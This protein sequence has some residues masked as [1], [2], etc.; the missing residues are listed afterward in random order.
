MGRLGSCSPARARRT[1]LATAPTAV[2]WPITRWLKISSN[3]TN[4]SRSPAIIFSTGM[5]VQR[6]TTLAILFSLTS[7]CTVRASP[8][9][10]SSASLASSP[11]M[12]P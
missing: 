6:A 5:P 1:V 3:C 7:S 11:G 12:V 8:L 10:S 9:A 4:R 2:S